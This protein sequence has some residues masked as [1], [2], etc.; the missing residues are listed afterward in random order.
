MSSL[1]ALTIQCGFFV[2]LDIE[3]EE[4]AEHVVLKDLIFILP[5]IDY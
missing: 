2:N 3:T 5:R 1:W 4:F